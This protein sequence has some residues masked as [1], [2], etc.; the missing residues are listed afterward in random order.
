MGFPT[1]TQAHRGTRLS[2]SPA[3]RMFAL[4]GPDW[5]GVVHNARRRAGFPGAHLQPRSDA[6][7]R[8]RG[9]ANGVDSESQLLRLRHS[10]DAIRRWITSWSPE[11]PPR[12]R[13]IRADGGERCWNRGRWGF[14]LDDG[15]RRPH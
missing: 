11:H 13:R 14:P 12:R 5:T 9:V 10:Y 1:P 3:L 6:D 15:R 7:Q 4:A 8:A 2:T